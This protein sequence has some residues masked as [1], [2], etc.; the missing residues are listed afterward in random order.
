MADNSNIVRNG[1]ATEESAE[2]QA[3]LTPEEAK[4]QLKKLLEESPSRRRMRFTPDYTLTKEYEELSKVDTS[5]MSEKEKEEHSSKLVYLKKYGL[6]TEEQRQGD[7]DFTINSPLSESFKMRDE[8]RAE[9]ERLEREIDSFDISEVQTEAD[10][11]T[12]EYK[13]RMKGLSYTQK[14]TLQA[15]YEKAIDDLEYRGITIPQNSLKVKRAEAVERY[16]VADNRIKLYIACNRQAI[17]KQIE[18]AKEAEINENLL[19]LAEY[20]GG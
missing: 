13:R 6:Y 20:I 12:A 4:E 11:I 5:S 14:A 16:R 3:Q 1:F 9:I 15:E 17:Q 8:C 19:A 7:I 18:R 2:A 10:A